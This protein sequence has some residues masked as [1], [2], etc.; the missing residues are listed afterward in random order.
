MSIDRLRGR[1]LQ[2]QRE[3]VWLRDPFCARCGVITTFPSGFELDHKVALANEG[4]NDDDNMQVLHHE[5]H[6]AK[7]N[8]DMGYT[9]KVATGLDG[10][11][12]DEPEQPVDSLRRRTARWKRVA[13]G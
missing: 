6:E 10:W 7:T 9:P 8:E 2:R 13:K 5:C 11:P 1:A 12:V 4:T 3:R